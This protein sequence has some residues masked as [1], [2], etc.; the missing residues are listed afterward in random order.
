VEKEP[1]YWL[2]GGMDLL[3]C[4]HILIPTNLIV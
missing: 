3:H 1:G 2:C 4:P